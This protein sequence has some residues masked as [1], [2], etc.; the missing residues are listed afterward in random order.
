MYYTFIPIENIDITDIR[1]KIG[2]IRIH[3]SKS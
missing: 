3:S 2:A 1:N